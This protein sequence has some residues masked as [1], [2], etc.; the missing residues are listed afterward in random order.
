MR[1]KIVAGNWKMHLSLQEG[2]E[3]VDKIILNEKTQPS[4]D[5]LKIIAPSFIHLTS[6]S[7]KL[8]PLTGFAISAQNCH[9][10]AEGAFTGE[11]SAKMIASTGAHYVII[12]HSERRHYFGETNQLL[13]KKINLSLKEKLIPIYC[14]GEQSEE[15]KNGSHF[16][17]VKQQLEVALFHLP[18][19]EIKKIIIAY[20]PVW[21]IGTGLTAT[22]NQAQ[23]M[24][25]FIRSEINSQYGNEVGAAISILYGGSCNA[26]NAKELFACKDVDGGLIGGASLNAADFVKIANSF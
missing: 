1:K 4:T 3:L 9:H 20:E 6:V 14:V 26:N 18:D 21:A 5:V 17:T 12:G 8:K 25:S 15:R 13:S 19:S 2:I 10:E 7:D 24:H 11:V 16:K 22:S 23:E